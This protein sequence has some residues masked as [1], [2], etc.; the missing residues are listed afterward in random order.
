MKN[1]PAYAI[2]SVDNALQLAVWLQAEGFIGTAEAAERLGVSRS[3]AHRL[4][5]MLLY[6][7]FARQGPDRRYMAGPHLLAGQSSLA[8]V[9]LMRRHAL[10]HM[11]RL[12]TFVDETV[13]LQVLEGVDVRF[14]ETVECAHH[15][16]VGDRTGETW[17][18]H[19]VSGGKA[20][21]AART[22]QDVQRI[23][24][25]VPSIDIPAF[26]SNLA[27]IRAQGYAL[28]R[29]EADSGI[30]GIGVVIPGDPV[31][32]AA[33]TV[34]IPAVRYDESQLQTFT[35]SLRLTAAAVADSFTQDMEQSAEAAARHRPRSDAARTAALSS[36]D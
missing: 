22:D 11:N 15:L 5:Q 2:E 25:P 28:N 4:L 18:S 26:L 12:M 36:N 33:L 29:D 14:I 20:L 6:R 7:D 34:G 23:L 16:R 3:T 21:L 19:Q 13:T 30:I 24:A 9:L 10:P 1:K 35:S 32:M 8:P 17:P 31:P 27:E